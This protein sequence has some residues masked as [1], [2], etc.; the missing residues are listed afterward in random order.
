MPIA[1][2]TMR[3]GKK[4]RLTNYGHSTEFEVLETLEENNFK[5]KDLNILE[6][7]EFQDLIRYGVGK[8]YDLTE[9]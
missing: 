7:Y 9:L 4:Y 1:P 5:V 6:E 2:N 3:I 8:D